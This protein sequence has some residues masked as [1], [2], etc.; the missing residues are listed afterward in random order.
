MAS[1]ASIRSESDKKGENDE[2]AT[3]GQQSD[4]DSKDKEDIDEA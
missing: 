3:S 1:I 2:D 4:E